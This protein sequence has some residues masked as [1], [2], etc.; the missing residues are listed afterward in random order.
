MLAPCMLFKFTTLT[1]V[2]GFLV[3]S[4][5]FCT[6]TGKEST[7][8]ALLRFTRR[9]LLAWKN[10]FQKDPVTALTRKWNP[11]Y[12]VTLQNPDGSLKVRV[13]VTEMWLEAQ[14]NPC[15]F[16]EAYLLHQAGYCEKTTRSLL[17]ERNLYDGKNL[18]GESKAIVLADP[19]TDKYGISQED[20]YRIP[21]RTL[22]PD[23][24]KLLSK[25]SLVLRLSLWLEALNV[26]AS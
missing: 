2:D 6:H 4:S 9:N 18:R 7:E 23:G 14:L 17:D 26:P 16:S 5:V 8:Q 13:S 12:S 22:A 10:V 1:G 19:Y 15:P 25:T 11:L 20:D 3:S 24:L 21:L